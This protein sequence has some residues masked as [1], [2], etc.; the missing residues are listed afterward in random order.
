MR[1]HVYPKIQMDDEG[2]NMYRCVKVIK[3]TENDFLNTKL[4]ESGI[5]KRVLE[6]EV[7]QKAQNTNSKK[8]ANY[9]CRT[10]M[11]SCSSHRCP[12]FSKTHIRLVRLTRAAF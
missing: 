10:Y 6:R 5:K 1:G 9:N 11:W 2:V 3:G 4:K 7:Y 8:K 12:F